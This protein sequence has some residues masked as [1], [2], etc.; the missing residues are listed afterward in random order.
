MLWITA[1]WQNQ[2]SWACW[3]LE[4]R[5]SPFLSWT[6]TP[7]MFPTD[8]HLSFAFRLYNVIQ[9]AKIVPKLGRYRQCPEVPDVTTMIKPNRGATSLVWP[10]HWYLYLWSI[11]VLTSSIILFSNIFFY[12][13]LQHWCLW[14]L[15][16]FEH[17]LFAGHFRGSLVW[18]AACH[19]D[20]G[21]GGALRSLQDLQ[22]RA[23]GRGGWRDPTPLQGDHPPARLRTGVAEDF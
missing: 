21:R 3:K 9:C 4:S 7:Q 12:L 2:N 16:P 17:L 13:V 5:S 8:V 22:S 19:E 1:V 14:Q 20:V 23:E 6:S 18:L 11:Y 10:R 15:W